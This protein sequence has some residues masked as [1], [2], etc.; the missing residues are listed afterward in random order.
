MADSKYFRLIV[1]WAFKLVSFFNR[2]FDSRP[3]KSLL[4]WIVFTLLPFVKIYFTHVNRNFTIEM[5][6]SRNV[7]KNSKRN[8]TMFRCNNFQIKLHIQ[9][10]LIVN[11]KICNSQ[12]FQSIVSFFLGWV[13]QIIVTK[14]RQSNYFLSF[15]HFEFF[16]IKFF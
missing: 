3:I 8:S 5:N 4:C 15:F 14:V 9:K 2:Q 10:S 16:F 13:E 1:L 7:L 11:F 6:N 12:K